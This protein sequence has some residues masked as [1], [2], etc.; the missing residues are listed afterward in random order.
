MMAK[1]YKVLPS[2]IVG[3]EDNYEAF[4]FNEA[5]A[6]IRQ[7]IEVYKLEPNFVKEKHYSSFRD[8]YKKLEK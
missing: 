5:C 4:C 1:M 2:Q 6:Y 3:I 8:F 7:Q